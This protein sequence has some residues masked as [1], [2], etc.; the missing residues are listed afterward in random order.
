MGLSNRKSYSA[1]VEMRLVLGATV[2]PLAQL[3]PSFAILKESINI[4]ATNARIEVV[5]DQRVSQ[6]YKIYLPYGISSTRFE[7]F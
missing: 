7:F 4:A 3:G 1:L 5:V 2:L 6:V